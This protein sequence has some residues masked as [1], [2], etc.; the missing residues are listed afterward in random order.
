MSDFITALQKI[1]RNDPSL[2]NFT[3]QV[4][5]GD[6]GVQNLSKALDGNTSLLSI[7]L[8]NNAVTDQSIIELAK[9]L[10]NNQHI[11]V[12][13][14]GKNDIKEAGAEHLAQLMKTNS[15]LMS[16]TL[17]NNKLDNLGIIQLSEGI[18][19]NI[20]LVFL[21][22]KKNN[23]GDTGAQHLFNALAN[24]TTLSI[25]DL[26][27]NLLSDTCIPH[28]LHMLEQNSTL[29][30]LYLEGNA[31]SEAN[32]IRINHLLER[33]QKIDTL[34]QKAITFIKKLIV[35]IP[36]QNT[37]HPFHE[38]LQIKKDYQ[39]T[40]E[41]LVP[42][43][44]QINLIEGA[45]AEKQI[46]I[47]LTN[48]LQMEAD[49]IA[50]FDD[51]TPNQK[52]SAKNQEWLEGMIEHYF[53]LVKSNVE[54]YSY[55]KL[56]HYLLQTSLNKDMQRLLELCLFYHFNPQQE[57]ILKP[58]PIELFVALSTNHTLLKT[59][60]TEV[61]LIDS[62]IL[63]I[64]KT[65]YEDELFAKEMQLKAIALLVEI[66]QN[67]TTSIHE[68]N[69]LL[70][71]GLNTLFC[72]NAHHSKTFYS[73][74]RHISPNCILPSENAE[75]EIIAKKLLLKEYYTRFT[76][77]Y[78]SNNFQ[79]QDALDKFFTQNPVQKPRVVENSEQATVLSF[80]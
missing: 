34:T 30:L 27:H 58:E 3:T 44:H 61:P 25:L 50:I 79:T 63:R 54:H 55:A 17:W 20:H 4:P 69:T 15:P 71:C 66:S 68:I 18:K 13:N 31:I 75:A 76:V 40:I 56:M 48:Q 47:M 5:I 7:D 74:L 24:N 52:K 62:Y 12:L 51:L 39:N 59:L 33:N 64:I 9:A 2:R 80:K 65:C 67:K 14:L 11:V 43:A 38:A 32:N 23:I 21:N 16:L 29:N 77:P 10:E 57:N 72:E 53:A 28:L 35:K 8:W 73:L 45:W 19:N 41:Q 42:S 70:L 78:S 22:V 60:R 6:Q 46:D 49:I 1:T 37:F 36:E 26:S